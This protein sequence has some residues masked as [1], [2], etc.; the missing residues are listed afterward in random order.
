MSLVAM[1]SEFSG[2][3]HFWVSGPEDAFFDHSFRV[4]NVPD[5]SVFVYD[6]F[7]EF[8]PVY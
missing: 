7:I 6:S 3:F 8:E 2:F 1:S 5:G 4:L